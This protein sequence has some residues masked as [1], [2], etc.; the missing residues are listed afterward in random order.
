MRVALPLKLAWALTVHK[1]QGMSLSRA[2]LMLDN[3]FDFGQVYVALSRV[4]SLAGLWVRGGR[5][6]QAV[7]KAHPDVLAFYRA[8][9]CSV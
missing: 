9:G 2:E 8:V 6:T 4:V 1:S 5:I 7:V 3:A